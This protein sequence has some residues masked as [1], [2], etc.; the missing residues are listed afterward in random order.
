MNPYANLVVRIRKGGRPK[1]PIEKRFAKK[2]GPP[3][4]QGCRLWLGAKSRNGNSDTVVGK[5]WY[6]DK[7]ANAHVVLWRMT[8][9]MY[10]EKQLHPYICR[11]YLCMNVE[12]WRETQDRPRIKSIAEIKDE[13]KLK[14]ENEQFRKEYREARK[15][16][17]AAA[18]ARKKGGGAKRGQFTPAFYEEMKKRGIEKA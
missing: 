6:E 9:G 2:L 7:V 8:Y 5:I 17:R 1:E 16:R 11:N 10:P 3:N 13:A 4:E 18:L 12:H 15:K 14:R